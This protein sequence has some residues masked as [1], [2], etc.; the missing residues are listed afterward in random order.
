M[1][2]RAAKRANKM[3]DKFSSMYVGKNFGYSKKFADSYEQVYGANDRSAEDNSPSAQYT[4]VT[5]PEGR[6]GMEITWS[7]PPV[8]SAT[9]PGGAAE[10]LGV[11]AGS[12]IVQIDGQD[13][14]V[15]IPEYELDDLM[16]KRPLV[17]R[18]GVAEAGAQPVESPDDP[19]AR[20]RRLG[21]AK[22]P[23]VLGIQD[24]LSMIGFIHA[25]EA[26]CIRE[27]QQDHALVMDRF[28]E[29][30]T[31]RAREGAPRTRWDMRLPL[32]P[33]VFDAVRKI[34]T[35]SGGALGGAFA[36]LAGGP[37]AELWELGVIV[38]EPGAAPQS[39]HFDAPEMCLF[40]AFVALQD[41][42]PEMGPTMFLQGTNTPAAHRRFGEDPAG[43]IKEAQSS[44]GLLNAGDAVVYDSRVL[45]CGSENLSQRTRVLLYLT[46]RH[47]GRDPKELGIQQHSIRKDLAGR[48]HLRDFVGQ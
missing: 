8:V 12:V 22:V 44:A 34:L 19:A 6:L 1:G 20:V 18:L 32:V 48:F 35:G 31:P 4:E 45:H 10:R 7:T 29:V 40:S 2:D 27:I 3:L 38:S 30:Q 23:K 26:S 16:G 33:V 42:S 39:V 15:P 5:F 37:D 24:C 47:P 21:V 14:T 28:S 9:V 36:S 43:F 46:F 41:V 17:L 13:A 11:K 25:E